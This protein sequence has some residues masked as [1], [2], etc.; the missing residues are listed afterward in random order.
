MGPS[1]PGGGA[2]VVYRDNPTP[3]RE[4]PA[5]EQ[6]RLSALRVQQQ[7]RGRGATMIVKRPTE[8]GDVLP[9]VTGAGASLLGAG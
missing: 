2:Q 5:I 6:A 4:D 1:S 7:Q 3:T 8:T 9:T